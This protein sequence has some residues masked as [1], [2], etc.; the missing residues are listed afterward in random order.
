M[1]PTGRH[2]CAAEATGVGFFV[3]MGIDARR[4]RKPPERSPLW[5]KILA[6][7]E[8]RLAEEFALGLL[9]GGPPQEL[10]PLSFISYSLKTPI[11]DSA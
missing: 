11:K 8:R 2:D 7:H 5:E 1:P 6:P 3:K 9:L 10:W 4:S